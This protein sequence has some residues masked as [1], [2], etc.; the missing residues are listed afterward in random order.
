MR[1]PT[2]A[3]GSRALPADL[4]LHFRIQQFLFLEARL[5]DGHCYDEWLA[6]WEPDAHY[7]IPCNADEI[8]R[9][10]HISLVNEDMVGLQDR[11]ARLK[12]QANFAQQPRSRISHVVGNVEVEPGGPPGEATVRSTL[13]LTAS[14]RGRLDVIA[15]RVRHHLRLFDGGPRI[16]SKKVTLINNDEVFGNLAFLV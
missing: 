7:W 14:R 8:D 4:E 9:T 2:P 5:M 15:G 16:V 13:N 6:L 10:Q 1:A 12:S 11:I 3:S